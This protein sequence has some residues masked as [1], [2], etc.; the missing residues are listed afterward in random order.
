MEGDYFIKDEEFL[1]KPKSISLKSIK[2][3][4]N[5]METQICKIKYD[6]DRY[7]TGF[8][9]N[10]PY[11]DNKFKV[12]ITNSHV[13]NKDDIS[14][15]KII[16]FSLDDERIKY[17][18]LMDE[19]RKKF[20]NEKYAITIIEIKENDKLNNIKYFDIDN[21]LFK[22]NS[23]EIFTN[24]SI[25]LLHYPRGENMEHSMGMIQSINEDNYTFQHLCN[26]NKGS[27]GAPLINLNNYQVIGVHN[28]VNTENVYNL[29][30]FLKE[31]IEKFIEEIKN[32]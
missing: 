16:R 15:N 28:E 26:S 7:G 9:C 25:I 29:G 27:S 3:I 1:T 17:E 22:E 8:F 19:S 13:L 20:I 11:D 18:I 4:L 30:I 21:R 2:I 5:I 23:K 10:I 24:E 32:N 14:I 31:P 6:N 12:L